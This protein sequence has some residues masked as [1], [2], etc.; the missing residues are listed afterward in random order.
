MRLLSTVILALCAT[1]AFA[2]LTT[3]V[4]VRIA[5][6]EDRPN[7][8]DM[9]PADGSSLNNPAPL[10]SCVWD[11]DMDTS[12]TNAT[13]VKLP[14]GLQIQALIWSDARTMI[15]QYTGTLSSYG[16]KR[17]DFADG[18]FLS[19]QGVGSNAMQGWAFNYNDPN[20]APFITAGPLADP[21]I[22]IAGTETTFTATALD[23]NADP[24]TYTWD[25]GDNSAA[26]TGEIVTH[27]FAGDGPYLVTVTVNDGRGGQVSKSIV[28]GDTNGGAAG[29][30]WIIT[31]GNIALNFK[32]SG[33]DK[34]QIAGVIELSKDAKIEGKSFVV[35]VGG[36]SAVFK[37]NAKGQ[38][39]LGKNS[40]K[41]TRKLVK[42]QFLGGPVKIQFSLSGSYVNALKD[43]GFTSTPTSKIG[44]QK[45]LR[46]ILGLDG[47]LY[48]ATPNV[49]WK[50]SKGSSGKGTFKSAVR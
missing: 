46:V 32:Q 13:R 14:D 12:R 45:L 15:L 24:L 37:L 1:H 36:A 3:S 2:D 48:S 41:L 33:K 38:A 11:R 16:A 7:I 5:R 23:P 8:I 18:Y 25:F 22:L 31:K 27:T 26:A 44:D 28:M 35:N 17:V 29:V 30:P 40:F 42:K 43:E 10:L 20:D 39:K 50:N 47:A 4:S 9:T 34:I 21:G 6:P 49:L 19:A